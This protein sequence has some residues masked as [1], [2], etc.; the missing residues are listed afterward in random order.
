M[1][2]YPYL[3]KCGKIVPS[4]PAWV[5]WH[6]ECEIVNATAQAELAAEG[7]VSQRAE[8][9]GPVAV[10]PVRKRTW[11]TVEEFRVYQRDYMRRYRA[12]RLGKTA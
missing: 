3:C 10:A 12:K 5:N 6:Q 2:S 11:K 7:S 4:H 1:R 8:P 9:L